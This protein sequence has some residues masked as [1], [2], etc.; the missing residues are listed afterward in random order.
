MAKTKTKQRMSTQCKIRQP[1]AVGTHKFDVVWIPKDKAIKGKWLRIDGREGNWQ[2]EEVWSTRPEA[3]LIDAE[4][5]YLKQRS[6]SDIKK[7]P[8]SRISKGHMEH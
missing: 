8:E 5:D 3:D 7:A 4:R 6:V 2:V 1:T